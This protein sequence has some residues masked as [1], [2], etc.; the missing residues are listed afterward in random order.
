MSGAIIRTTGVQVQTLPSPFPTSNVAYLPTEL[1]SNIVQIVLFPDLCRRTC[2]NVLPL[3]LISKSF[4]A[5]TTST[6]EYQYLRNARLRMRHTV[7][8][9]AHKLFSVGEAE[10]Y[11]VSGKY[12]A[13]LRAKAPAPAFTL[14]KKLAARRKSA[15]AD[16]RRA[17][18]G[19]LGR[20]L[21]DAKSDQLLEKAKDWRAS[22]PTPTHDRDDRYV[23]KQIDE[24]DGKVSDVENLAQLSSRIQSNLPTLEA[25]PDLPKAQTTVAV[26]DFGHCSCDDTNGVIDDDLVTWVKKNVIW[27][28]SAEYLYWLCKKKRDLKVPQR[29]VSSRDYDAKERRIIYHRFMDW[30]EG[31]KLKE[32]SFYTNRK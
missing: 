23:R 28:G 6:Q 13:I 4:K 18:T 27:S 7:F 26:C 17:P 11:E 24:V 5:V 16:L 32:T 14:E 30:Y 19:H 8:S 29:R 10:G 15:L 21:E 3:L 2:T 12:V 25:L 31:K 1:W 9:S 20:E 22:Q